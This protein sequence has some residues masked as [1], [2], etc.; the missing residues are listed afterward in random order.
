MKEKHCAN[1]PKVSCYEM[2]ARSA[3]AN[4]RTRLSRSAVRPREMSNRENAAHEFEYII[5][6]IVDYS[7][8]LRL[9]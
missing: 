3:P 5:I 2:S 9:M 7:D 8:V 6:Y 1:H 4:A